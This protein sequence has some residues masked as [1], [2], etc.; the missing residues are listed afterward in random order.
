MPENVDAIP[1]TVDFYSHLAPFVQFYKD[2]RIKT[3]YFQL[4]FVFLY[5]ICPMASD[6]SVNEK[7]A[8]ASHQFNNPPHWHPALHPQRQKDGRIRPCWNGQQ[9]VCFHLYAPIVRQE[10]A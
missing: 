6:E 4:F 3:C 2:F 1:E 8:T 10:Y 5:T 9:P 7:G